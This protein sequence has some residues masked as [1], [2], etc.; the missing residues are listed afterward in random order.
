MA[1]VHV[2]RVYDPGP[3]QPVVEWMH[4][5]GIYIQE[6]WLFFKCDHVE[7]LPPSRQL[8]QDM[9]AVANNASSAVTELTVARAQDG[10]LLHVR[11]KPLDPV[12]MDLFHGRSTGGRHTAFSAKARINLHTGNLDPSWAT[13][14]AFIFGNQRSMYASAINESG[15]NLAQTRL[16]LWGYR[17][18]LA[19]LPATVSAALRKYVNQDEL[20]DAEKEIVRKVNK[21]TLVPAQGRE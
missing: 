3:I 9:G 2:A 16:Q 10:N 5:L 14:T 15:Y 20:T 4:N 19:P 8:V 12:E 11:M 13:T 6:D 1:V 21:V 7:G 18:R 17:Y